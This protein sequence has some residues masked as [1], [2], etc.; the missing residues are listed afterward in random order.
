MRV[1]LREAAWLSCV[2][3][4]SARSTTPAVDSELA[5]T[6]RVAASPEVDANAGGSITVMGTLGG[7][8]FS[9]RG[10][11]A[12]FNLG[13]GPG[14][15]PEVAVG[16]PENFDLTC[17]LLKKDMA[18]RIEH[19]NAAALDL[20]IDTGGPP[21][22]PG[23]YPVLRPDAGAASGAV[24]MTVSGWYQQLDGDCGAPSPETAT[25]GSV[26]VSAIDRTAISGSFDLTFPNGD[27]VT[28][29]FSAPVCVIN[30]G[31]YDAPPPRCVP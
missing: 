11:L 18:S 4:C 24:A 25:S 2:A 6:P 29:Q 15:P 22:R 31:G 20:F 23:V 13:F 14:I 30:E 5:N 8:P 10:A 7:R 21:V 1:Y 26:V 17:D 16:M 27:F 12:L 3:A 28:G 19:A 9:A